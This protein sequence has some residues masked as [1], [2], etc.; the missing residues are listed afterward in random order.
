MLAGTIKS[1]LA[2]ET[3]ATAIEY[4]LVAALVAVAAISSF[5]VFGDALVNL[6]G[7]GAGGAAEIMAA[8]G[9]KIN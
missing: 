9:A 3:G 2:D 8:Q 1:L 4:G 7:Y 6:M 5:L